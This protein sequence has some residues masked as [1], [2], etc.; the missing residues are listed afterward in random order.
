MSAFMV[1]SETIASIAYGLMSPS[2]PY[3]LHNPDGMRSYD[4]SEA[5][6]R[7]FG[8]GL[9]GSE[10]PTKFRGWKDLADWM[11]VMNLEA[12]NYRY[13]REDLL[14]SAEGVDLEAYPVEL[15]GP[16][17]FEELGS[18]LYQCT[19]GEEIQDSVLFTT[20]DAICAQIPYY[21]V[22]DSKE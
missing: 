4:L 14:E 21:I 18:F 1:S 10:A 8:V 12:L 7:M 3:S 6:E 16:A 15:S 11:H 20:M 13:G 17:L 22:M 2:Q 5:G 9:A 19:E